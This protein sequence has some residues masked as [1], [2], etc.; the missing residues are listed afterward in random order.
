MIIILPQAVYVIEF[1]V[2]N[3]PG[4]ALEQIKEKGYHRKYLADNRTVYIIGIGFD[5]NKKNITEFEWE[6]V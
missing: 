5:S 4:T 2:D 3:V 6:K 1:K